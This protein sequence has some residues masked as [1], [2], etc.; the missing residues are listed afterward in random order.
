MIHKISNIKL[1]MLSHSHITFRGHRR[2]NG[3]DSSVLAL[4]NEPFRSSTSNS[5]S[6]PKSNR[7]EIQRKKIRRSDADAPRQWK[8][9][10]MVISRW[11]GHIAA[12]RQVW[13]RTFDV[14]SFQ[15]EKIQ[16]ASTSMKHNFIYFFDENRKKRNRANRMSVGWFLSK[17]LILEIVL[18]ILA[19]TYCQSAVA[20]THV[21]TMH[22]G[23]PMRRRRRRQQ[24]QSFVLK[25]REY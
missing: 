13:L 9:I 25:R 12:H 17:F 23:M 20:V 10:K 7:F 6:R 2:I 21:C 1:S 11:Y 4:E 24:Q 18:W 5:C 22:H 3:C 16:I 14:F 8:W 19:S 15:F